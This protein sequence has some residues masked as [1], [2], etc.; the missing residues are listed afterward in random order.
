M[1]FVEKF[2]TVTLYGPNCRGFTIRGSAAYVRTYVV[3]TIC[4]STYVVFSQNN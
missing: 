4:T 2:T 3:R 1:S